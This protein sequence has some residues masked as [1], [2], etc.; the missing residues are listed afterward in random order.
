MIE[1]VPGASKMIGQ[2]GGYKFEGAV[3]DDS[4]NKPTQ[5]TITNTL[6]TNSIEVT[7]TWVDA[8]NRDNL[9][10]ETLTFELYRDDETEPL[11]SKTVN[12]TAD[13]IEVCKFEDLPVYKEGSTEKHRYYVIEKSVKVYETEYSVDIKTGTLIDTNDVVVDEVT[14]PHDIFLFNAE[15]VKEWDDESDPHDLRPA[16]VNLKLQYSVDGENWTDVSHIEAVPGPDTDD[17]TTVF[18]TSSVEQTLTRKDTAADDP[19]AWGPARWENL[20]AN[21]LVDG[22]SK[23]VSYRVVEVEPLDEYYTVTEFTFAYEGEAETKGLVSGAVSNKISDFTQL[24]VTKKWKDNADH[25]LKWYRLNNVVVQLQY[26]TDDDDAWKDVPQNGE[27]IL[28][29]SNGWTHT[30]TEL[31]ADYQYRVVERSIKIGFITHRVQR[32]LK[33][34]GGVVLAKVYNFN[35]KGVTTSVILD[36]GV[37]IYFTE[38]TNELMPRPVVPKTGDDSNLKMAGAACGTS[39]IGLLGAVSVLAAGKRKKRKMRDDTPL[40]NRR[41]HLKQRF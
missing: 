41:D 4:T 37:K 28:D 5:C 2:I 40:S 23:P 30:F 27:A 15:V 26:R 18:T 9:R 33:D 34:E 29:S 17:G 1:A 24:T 10:P 7:K 31:R 16:S 35:S 8:N 39:A 25:D 32:I 6:I 3:A 38:L 14:N 36:N 19:D 12:V 22:E 13:G 21:V 11:E 20:P